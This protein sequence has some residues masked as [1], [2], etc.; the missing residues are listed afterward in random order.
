MFRG[1]TQQLRED[2]L[3]KNGCYGIQVPDDDAEVLRDIMGPAQGFSGKYKDDLT[4]QVLNDVLVDEARAKEL[5]YSHSEGV[6]R[7]VAWATART[8][9]GRPPISVRWVDV[10]KG[11]E[12]N[13]NYRSRLVARQ[14]KAHDKSGETYFAPAPPLDALRTVLSFA[15]TRI[16]DHQPIWEPNHPN[17]TQLSFIDTQHAKQG[18]RGSI[19]LPYTP[20]GVVWYAIAS[21][22][23]SN[24]WLIF[25][26]S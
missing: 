3:L 11:D 22:L 21:I 7:K 12:Q 24:S 13:P 26:L 17:R 4:G 6:W 2:N 23:P 19:V 14:L 20:T 18:D 16:G 5:L 10:N 8:A 1:V 25:W 15:M 9:T